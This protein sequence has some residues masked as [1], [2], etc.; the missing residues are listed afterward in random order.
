MILT[1]SRGV[2]PVNWVNLKRVSVK[3]DD[4]WFPF[5]HERIDVGVCVVVDVGLDAGVGVGDGV[6]V[7]PG[8]VIG[9]IAEI[10]EGVVVDAEVGVEQTGLFILAY[11]LQT[12]VDK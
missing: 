11:I 7:G 2:D 10:S 9:C 6:G 4:T 5:P 12:F 1:P 8:V 3:S